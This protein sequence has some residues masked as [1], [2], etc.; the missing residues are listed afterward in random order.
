[1]RSSRSPERRQTRSEPY[2]WSSSLKMT[3]GLPMIWTLEAHI[4]FELLIFRKC[5]QFIFAQHH[6]LTAFWG[7]WPK[8]LTV[9]F[10]SFDMCQHMFVKSSMHPKIGFDISFTMTRVRETCQTPIDQKKIILLAL[11]GRRA[12]RN[13]GVGLLKQSYLL[14]TSVWF[15]LLCLRLF[16]HGPF[17]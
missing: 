1:M 16:L 5:L 17:I 8:C 2:D 9:K 3:P 10:I 11:T 13:R 7:A 15:T 6:W 12:N 4:N 14:T